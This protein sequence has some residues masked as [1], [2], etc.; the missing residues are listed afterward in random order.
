MKIIEVK[1]ILDKKDIG[2]YIAST[3]AKYYGYKSLDIVFI[4]YAS[5][6]SVY[7]L[8]DNK[9]I[10]DITLPNDFNYETNESVIRFHEVS[11]FL[12]DI[13]TKGANEFNLEYQNHYRLEDK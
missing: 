10:V 4:G 11:K 2:G 8:P 5:S 12:K 7:R 6:G 9:L 3:I 13:D 1:R